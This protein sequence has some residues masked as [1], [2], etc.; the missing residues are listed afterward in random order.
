MTCSFA[1][2]YPTLC[3]LADTSTTI[4]ARAEALPKSRPQTHN[5]KDGRDTRHKTHHSTTVQ[6]E[7][8]CH[9]EQRTTTRRATRD[10]VDCLSLLSGM[11]S[12]PTWRVQYHIRF[13]RKVSQT[14]IIATTHEGISGLSS[15]TPRNSPDPQKQSR[16]RGPLAMLVMA[17]REALSRAV[18]QDESLTKR[19]TKA[20]EPMVVYAK[21]RWKRRDREGA[22]DGALVRYGFIKI[23]MKVV[24]FIKNIFIKNHFHQKPLSSKTTFIKNNFHQ[25]HFHQTTLIKIQFH[26]KPFSSKTIFIKNH[27]HQKQLSSRTIFIKNDFHQKTPNAPKP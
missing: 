21:Q 25:N 11:S 10:S 24:N 20:G 5:G 8:L 7:Q 22:G 27:F 12:D 18:H 23:R 3:G 26:Q 9:C 16:S 2:P 15:R 1:S 19:G 17:P 6:R 14:K 13:C 4:C